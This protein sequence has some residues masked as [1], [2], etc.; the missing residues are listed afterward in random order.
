MTSEIG[1]FAS[2]DERDWAEE[3]VNIMAVLRVS[4]TRLEF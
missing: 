4:D 3:H 1:V 2:Y